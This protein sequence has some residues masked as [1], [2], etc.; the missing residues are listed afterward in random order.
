MSS[1]ATRRI[2][3]ASSPFSLLPLRPRLHNTVASSQKRRTRHR[4]RPRS[5]PNSSHVSFTLALRLDQASDRAKVVCAWEPRARMKVRSPA[6]RGENECQLIVHCLPCLQYLFAAIDARQGRQKGGGR[7]TGGRSRFNG[8]E[9]KKL[10]VDASEGV[11][12]CWLY[13]PGLRWMGELRRRRLGAL[14]DGAWCGL[15][16]EKSSTQDFMD[17]LERIVNEIKNTT[18]SAGPWAS[19]FV[20]SLLIS[21]CTSRSTLAPSYK[22]SRRLRWQTT[23]MVC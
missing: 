6:T 14:A 8:N 15:Q 20:E 2:K 13:S 19:S 10:M 1:S 12:G 16:D 17:T 3:F 9:L 7:A 18:V 23:M 5:C 22:R 4:S 21:F 11:V